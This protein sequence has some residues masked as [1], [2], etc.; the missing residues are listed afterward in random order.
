MG[1]ETKGTVR[2]SIPA[3]VAFDLKKLHRTIESVAERLGC[4]T[5]FSGAECKFQLERDFVF[6]E[7]IEFSR[8][9]HFATVP[10]TAPAL[11][12]TVTVGL[13]TNT[14]NNLDRIKDAVAT[15]AGQLGCD[16]CCSG[17]DINFFKERV[18]LFG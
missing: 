8:A 12:A 13:G 6:N 2:I 7:K 9:S 5:C 18:F 10:D 16:G 14:A 1:R 15:V 4:K 17:F 3:E 11:G